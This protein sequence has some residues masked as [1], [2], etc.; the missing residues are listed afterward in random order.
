MT[1]ASQSA[2]C[3][4]GMRRSKKMHLDKPKRPDSLWKHKAKVLAAFLALC[5]VTAYSGI[6]FAA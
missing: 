6:G 3:R 5:L 4:P 2:G 1:P